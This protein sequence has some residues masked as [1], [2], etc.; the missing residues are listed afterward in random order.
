MHV[1]NSLIT[2]L[3]SARH[4][5]VLT[6][7][8]MSAE[9]GLPTFRDPDNGLWT[10][11]QLAALATPHAMHRNPYDVWEAVMLL[12][13]QAAA[14]QPHAGHAALVALEHH[15]PQ[16][17]LMTQN[18]DRLHQRAGSRAVLELHGTPTRVRCTRCAYCG[19]TGDAPTHR[20]PTCPQCGALV[21]PDVVWFGELLAEDVWAAAQQA[22]KRCDVFFAIGTSGEVEPVASLP[23]RA[24][25]HGARLIVINP[26]VRTHLDSTIATISGRAGTVLPALVDAVWSTV[27]GPAMR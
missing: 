19:A 17:T 20:V 3:R 13:E 22:A 1:P 2:A 18:V 11:E 9:S 8:G 4:V 12:A 23:Q 6:G 7:A 21:R 24:L 16:F 5:A 10:R 25:Q 15:V 27:P 26:D 14:A